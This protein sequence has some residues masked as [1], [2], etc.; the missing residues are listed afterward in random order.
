MSSIILCY[1]CLLAC[2]LNTFNC[3]SNL[4]NYFNNRVM[5]FNNLLDCTRCLFFCRPVFSI[6]LTN[7]YANTSDCNSCFF[8]LFAS[9]CPRALCSCN[10]FICLY[11]LFNS[12]HLSKLSKPI[13]KTH[14]S[15][16]QSKFCK[17]AFIV[18]P[19]SGNF[20]NC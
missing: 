7:Q 20:S 8:N 3:S 16:L 18:L 17:K 9:T 11:N 5:C 14:K 13:C 19:C 1:C 2:T 6:F 12:R 15:A 4:F 10:L